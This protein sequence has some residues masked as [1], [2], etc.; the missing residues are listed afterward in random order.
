MPAKG[1]Y[2]AI[3]GGGA[4][5]LWSGIRGK[6]VTGVLRDVISGKNPNT[7]PAANTVVSASPYLTSNPNSYVY[8]GTQQTSG[9]AKANQALARTIALA[10]GHPTWI[11]G[12]QWQDWVSLWNME[13]GWNQYAQNASSGAY[14]IP[15]AL[16]LTKMPKSAWPAAHG[17][18]SNASAQIAWGITYI[19][20]R[21]GSP[22]AA[23]AHEMSTNPHWY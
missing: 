1:V 3:T 17:G 13:S 9:S 5:L 18:S 14:G 10:M 22:S 12:Q 16:P 15:Q 23:W 20:Q 21:Y 19:A 11:V 8:S 7:A 4:I 6:S 2:L